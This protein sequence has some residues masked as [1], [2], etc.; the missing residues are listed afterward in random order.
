MVLLNSFICDSRT[1]N[2]FMLCEPLAGWR[3]VEV[4]ERRTMQDFAHQMRSL[5]EMAYP[6]AE[7]IRLVLD[8]LNTHSLA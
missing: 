3:H 7:K 6:Q 5:V 2:L 8:N 4:T 1:R